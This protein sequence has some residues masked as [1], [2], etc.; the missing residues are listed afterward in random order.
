MNTIT[1]LFQKLG[2]NTKVGVV[3]GKG[4]TTVSEMK[5]RGSIP[6]RYWPLLLRAA[7]NAGVDLD[8]ATLVQIHAPDPSLGRASS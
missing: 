6:V 3:I 4:Q 5:R 8:E 7:Q 2:G 1:D